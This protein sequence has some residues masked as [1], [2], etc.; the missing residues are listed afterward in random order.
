MPLP[1]RHRMQCRCGAIQG[2]VSPTR[3]AVRYICYCGDCQSYALFLRATAL[4]GPTGGTEL[5]RL[6]PSQV[7][8][9]SGADRLCCIR[10]TGHGLLR[11]YSGCC[12][13]PIANTDAGWRVSWVSLVRTCLGNDA[14]ALEASFGPVRLHLGQ[15]SAQATPRA[16]RDLMRLP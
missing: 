13:T 14:G 9:T 12:L 7:A 16:S 6:S 8:I 3:P 11:W 5:I 15:G 1:D 4:L 2:F 10:L